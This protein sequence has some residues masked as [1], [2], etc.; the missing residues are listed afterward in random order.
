MDEPETAAEHL[1]GI[2]RLAAFA[3][4]HWPQLEDGDGV[5]PSSD[6]AS[7]T[8]TDLLLMISGGAVGALEAMQKGKV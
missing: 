3:M 5:T 6:D 7:Q 2:L 4:E 8:K 1:S